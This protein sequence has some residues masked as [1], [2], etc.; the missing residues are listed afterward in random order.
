MAQLLA[1]EDAEMRCTGAKVLSLML[2]GKL[3]IKSDPGVSTFLASGG[4]AALVRCLEQEKCCREVEM[5]GLWL[6][7]RGGARVY[8]QDLLDEMEGIR[9]NP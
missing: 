2:R 4:Q 3:S 5:G 9:Y 7:E 8:L 6:Q 1:K